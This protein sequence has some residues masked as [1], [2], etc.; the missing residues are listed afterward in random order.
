MISNVIKV[1]YLKVSTNYVKETHPQQQLKW[2]D[3]KVSQ[4]NGVE[5]FGFSG[6][7]VRISCKRFSRHI[8]E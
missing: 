5:T 7:R 4:K 2:R 8:H 6:I 1:F 3:G